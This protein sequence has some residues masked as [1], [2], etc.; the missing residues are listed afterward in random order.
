MCTSGNTT[1]RLAHAQ[2]HFD[3]TSR[4]RRAFVWYC[5]TFQSCRGTKNLIDVLTDLSGSIQPYA[6]GHAHFGM[7][8]GA[9]WFAHNEVRAAV[10][11]GLG[12]VRSVLIMH[13]WP[14]LTVDAAAHDGAFNQDLSWLRFTAHWPLSWRG[15]G[16]HFDSHATHNVP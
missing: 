10:P 7:L 1:E 16:H 2:G 12:V 4:M 9:A 3:R 11:R 5:L 6:G 14:C 13:A 8:H 15:R